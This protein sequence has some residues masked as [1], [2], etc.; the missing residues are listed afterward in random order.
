MV[1]NFA[2]RGQNHFAEVF[3]LLFRLWSLRAEK[4]INDRP[5]GDALRKYGLDKPIWQIALHPHSS[6][7]AGNSV[8]S[9]RY[10]LV[11]DRVVA[12]NLDKLVDIHLDSAHYLE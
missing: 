11:E 7:S 10:L 1:Q 2:L 8:G 12:V 9:L 5:D 6:L 3:A 4:I